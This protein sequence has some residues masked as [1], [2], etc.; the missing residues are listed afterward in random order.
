MPYSAALIDMKPEAASEVIGFIAK[1]PF[2]RVV[3]SINNGEKLG[4][5]ELFFGSWD[6]DDK[7][8]LEAFCKEIHDKGLCSNWNVFEP[9]EGWLKNW[10][11]KMKEVET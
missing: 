9:D 5:Y 11:K 10:W 3:H 6:D 7:P 1:L 8:Y 2:K 4:T